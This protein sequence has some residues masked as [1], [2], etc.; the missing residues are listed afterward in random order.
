MK[1]FSQN[2]MVSQIVSARKKKKLTQQELAD[3]SGMNR[4]MVVRLEAADYMP[5]IEQLDRLCSAL[6]LDPASFYINNSDYTKLPKASPLNIAVAGTGYVG[7]SIA[8]LLSQHNHVTAVDISSLTVEED[9]NARNPSTKGFLALFMGFGI[10]V[11]WVLPQ[12]IFDLLS[13]VGGLVP[14]S[15]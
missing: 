4:G 13:H 7:L 8:T 1:S 2:L 14:L 3:A 10:V 12:K 11:C 9:N 15:V 6:D 5:S